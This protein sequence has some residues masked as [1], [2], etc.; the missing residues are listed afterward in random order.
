MYFIEELPK[1]LDTVR[2]FVTDSENYKELIRLCEENEKAG[3]EP[4]FCFNITMQKH[5]GYIAEPYEDIVAKGNEDNSELSTYLSM[6]N[7]SDDVLREL[8]RYFEQ[9]DE[10][11]IILFFGD[12]QP[13]LRTEFYEKIYGKPY[14]SFTSEEL[15]SVYNVPY[16]IWSNYELNKEAAPKETSICYLANILFETGNIPKS[17]W[18]NMFAEYQKSYPIVTEN[19]IERSDGNVYEVNTIMNT[20]AKNKKDSLNLYQKYSYGI[21]YGLKNWK[22]R[23]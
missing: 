14:V 21:L 7:K 5:G 16:L 23:D 8:I 3:D 6:I 19:F 9:V 11:T 22:A 1:G 20:I 10:D 2:G 12:H 18:L 4:F 17:T 13:L 15:K